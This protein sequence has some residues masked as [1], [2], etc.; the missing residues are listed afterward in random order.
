MDSRLDRAAV[1]Y[2]SKDDDDQNRILHT[3]DVSIPSTHASTGHVSK[4]TQLK[5]KAREILHIN[6]SSTA[7]TEPADHVTLAPVP[8]SDDL[9]YRLDNHPPKEGLDGLRAFARQPVQTVKAK[10][11]RKTNRE[12]AGNLATAEVS[13][14]HDVELLMAQN[15]MA[16]ANTEEERRSTYRDLEVL[17]KARQDMYVR[18]TMDRHVLKIRQREMDSSPPE[19]KAESVAEDQSG[20]V[21]MNWKAYGG[22]VRQTHHAGLPVECLLT[23]PPNIQLALRYSEKYGGQYIGSFAEPPPASQE[24]ISASIERLLIASTPWQEVI[25]NIRRIYRWEN[26][27]ETL[28]YLVIFLFLWVANCV[29][30]A[31]VNTKIPIS[32]CSCIQTRTANSLLASCHCR[33]SLTPPSLPANYREA[34]YENHAYGRFP[35]YRS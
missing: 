6:S 21:K 32:S 31:I 4:K 28:T 14:A 1:E 9:P 30:S 12:V 5:Q 2:D 33:P 17:K 27:N 24:T 3:T 20:H 26:S 19:E 18:W 29:A 10:V 13:H 22:H 7:V 34:S 35:G 23:D 8:N 16:K 15:Q 11:E 25:M